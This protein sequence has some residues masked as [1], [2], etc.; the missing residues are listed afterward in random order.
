MADYEF[1]DK[2]FGSRRALKVICIG[3]GATGIDF[4]KQVSTQESIERCRD[5]RIR[6]EL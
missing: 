6:K 2:P 4:V 5:R 1:P 3:A